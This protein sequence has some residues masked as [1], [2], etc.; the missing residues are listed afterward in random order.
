MDNAK[1]AESVE[2][3]GGAPP[4]ISAA[5]RR[6]QRKAE[7]AALKAKEKAEKK[8]AAP[9]KSTKTE[10]LDPTKYYD[11]R[12]TEVQT[13]RSTGRE[14]YPH[15]WHWTLRLGEF[16]SKY[17]NLI[18]DQ[19][20]EE[21]QSVSGRVM[22]VA[23]SGSKLKFFDLHGDD[24][25]IQVMASASNHTDA[26]MEFT[27]AIDAVHR[28]DIV[29]IEGRPGRSKTGELSI[30]ASKIRVLSPCYHML[31]SSK[32]SQELANQEIRYRQR[33]LDFIC[34]PDNKRTFK[35]RSEII[36][37][38][39]RFFDQRD[40]VE[41]E[42]PYMHAVHGG[43]SARPFVTHHN[44]LNTQ[45]FMRVAPELYL[46][47][48]TVGGMER[49]YEIGKNFRNEGIDLTHNPEFTAIE[50]YC[51]YWD[52]NDLLDIT[53]KL[54]SEMVLAIHGSQKI[55]YHP[56]GPEGREVEIDFSPPFQ[57]VS[58]IAE[59]EKKS[60]EVIPRPLHSQEAIDHMLK[61]CA[62]HE[63]ELPHP[64]TAA[65]LI[66]TLCGHFI[67]DGLV[68]PTFIIDHPEIMSP[69]AKWHRTLPEMTERGELFVCGKELANFYTELNDPFKQRSLFQQQVQDAS[70][71][72]DEAQ[73][74][75]EGFCTALEHGLPPTGGWGLGIDRLT[76]F[77]AD[78]HNI[79]E[80]I[81]FPAMRPEVR[82]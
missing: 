30:F 28:G 49:V 1:Q 56:D 23:G 9:A 47:M 39:R 65:K 51:A 50:F 7:Q 22:R 4:Q 71:G 32:G 81:L 26:E 55:S 2:T 70:K 8:A 10:E 33:Y 64:A 12:V 16:K 44:D 73:P 25:K 3:G 62:K 59:I 82:K 66:D 57:R 74:Y 45:L 53:E 76:M 61:V 21:F 43:A 20:V 13:I 72:D 69:L 18:P 67:E 75:D 79:K 14:V 42:T 63:I 29:G 15:K 78:K 31:P 11:N 19:T 27:A 6:R 48:L 37:F 58:M 54:L 80:V 46:K 34:N 24:T 40:F 5:E 35:V 17:E 77:L 68:N 36:S 52:Y 60:G 41:V 38:L